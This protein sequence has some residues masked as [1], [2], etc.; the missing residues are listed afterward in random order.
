M[1]GNWTNWNDR[2]KENNSNVTAFRGMLNAIVSQDKDDDRNNT[3]SDNL[4]RIIA[5]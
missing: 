4:A 3:S 2:S 5:A 1:D